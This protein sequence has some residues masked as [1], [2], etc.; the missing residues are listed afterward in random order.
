[1][2]VGS[3]RVALPSQLPESDKF[4]DTGVPLPHIKDQD[5]A[6]KNAIDQFVNA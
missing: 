2:Q 6:Y 3:T 1:M 5:E 4:F